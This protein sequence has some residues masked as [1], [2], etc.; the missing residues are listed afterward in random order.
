M[1]ILQMIIPASRPSRAD[2]HVP[3][4]S[5]KRAKTDRPRAEH[6]T[7]DDVRS[8]GGGCPRI[9]ARQLKRPIR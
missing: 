8:F 4:P 3:R 7:V 1:G 6:I 2:R 9:A 5:Q